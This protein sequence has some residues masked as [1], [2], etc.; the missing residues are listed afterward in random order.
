MLFK[1]FSPICRLFLRLCRLFA[2]WRGLCVN[3]RYSSA[4]DQH[5]LFAFGCSHFSVS[6]ITTEWEHLKLLFHL[7]N[8]LLEAESIVCPLFRKKLQW[9]KVLCPRFATRYASK[10]H[11]VAVLCSYKTWDI[12][13]L[14]HKRAYKVVIWRK[15][16]LNCNSINIWTFFGVPFFSGKKRTRMKDQFRLHS[17]GQIDLQTCKQGI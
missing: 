14:P 11:Y 3:A 1:H 4:T 16:N 5:S 9:K 12:A 13:N 8:A 6:L 2:V 10:G 17:H 7:H 15:M